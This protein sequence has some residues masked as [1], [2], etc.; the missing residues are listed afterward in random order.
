MVRPR[1]GVRL[2]DADLKRS[3]RAPSVI[4]PQRHGSSYFDVERTG[5]TRVLHRCC[6]GPGYDAVT[7]LLLI[8]MRHAGRGRDGESAKWLLGGQ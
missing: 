6:S 2:Y 5:V 4:C 1:A 7:D 8:R 3:A